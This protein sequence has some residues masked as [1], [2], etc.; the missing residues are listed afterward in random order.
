MNTFAT[1]LN[2]KSLVNHYI[3]SSGASDDSTKTLKS[4][5][6]LINEITGGMVTTEEAAY[7]EAAKDTIPPMPMGA[8]GRWWFNKGYQ[9]TGKVKLEAWHEAIVDELT[10]LHMYN[11]SHASNPKKALNDIIVYNVE[12][13]LDPKV[14]S[15]AQ[16]L[17]D[18]G[19]KKGLEAGIQQGKDISAK[20]YLTN[21]TN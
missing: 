1:L 13:A 5:V 3:S 7:Q 21:S 19:Y 17:I 18:E 15:S 6:N 12:I 20:E 8:I 14:S 9:N 11:D 4:A 10:V 16:A 2:I